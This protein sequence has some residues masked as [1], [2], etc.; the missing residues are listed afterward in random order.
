MHL[1]CKPVG[2]AAVVAVLAGALPAASSA[3]PGSYPAVCNEAQNSTRGVLT[4]SDQTDPNPPARHKDAAM[5]VG[6][7]HG[8]GLVNAAE[9]S[10]ALAL[11][12][13]GDGGG[14]GGDDGGGIV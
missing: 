10:P 2:V 1:I 11:C 9:N 4:V 7:G 14:G 3:E 12:D 5:Q 8:A 6:N 13:T